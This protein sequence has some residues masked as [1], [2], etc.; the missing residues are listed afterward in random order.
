MYTS[1]NAASP[2]VIGNAAFVTEGYTEGGAMI[3]FAPDGSTKLRWQARKFSSQFTTPVAHQGYLY[4]VSGT[5][6]TEMVCY[7]IATGREMWRD[8]IDLKGAR[9]GRASLLHIDGAFLCLGAQ[10]TLLWLDLDPKGAK[11]LSQAQLFL[12][13]ETWGVPVVSRGLL[14]INQN[15]MGSRLVCYDLR[16]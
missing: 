16:Q 9:L 5:G 12:A 7:E 3:D 14:Y 1:V 15:A 8:G 13:P 11:I 10:G 2:V 6:G 4:G